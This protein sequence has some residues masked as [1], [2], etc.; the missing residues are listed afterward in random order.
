MSYPKDCR[1]RPPPTAHDV[2]NDRT[3]TVARRGKAH[4]AGGRE[5]L[6]EGAES[7]HS[8][9]DV[10]LGDIDLAW[11]WVAFAPTH[12]GQI[13]HWWRNH[14]DFWDAWASFAGLIA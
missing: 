4:R 9:N 8:R 12:R 3:R 5:R 10:D 14:R 13:R 6:V 2:V 11:H 1:T 7:G